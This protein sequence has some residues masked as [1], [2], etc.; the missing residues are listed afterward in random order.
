VQ[1]ADGIEGDVDAAGPRGHFVGVAQHGLFVERID[2]R[3]V[4]KAAGSGDV[5]GHRVE[6]A[7]RA[8]REK[9]PG[10]GTGKGAGHRAADGA[11]TAVDDRALALQ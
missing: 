3:H 7:A 10:P 2:H 1:H 6:L 5:P 9:H 11:A 8:A 4:G